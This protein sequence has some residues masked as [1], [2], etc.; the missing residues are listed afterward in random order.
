[1]SEPDAPTADAPDEALV[2]E[3]VDA[4]AG[5]PGG[6]SW[7]KVAILGV[8]LAFLGGSIGYLVGHRAE[9]ADPLSGTDVGF[10]QDMGLHHSQAVE[11]SLLLLDKDG[12]DR[13]LRSFAQ[14]III[15][16]RREIGIF[17]ATLDRFG[18]ATDPGDMVMGWMGHAV[19]MDQ[20]EGMASDAQMQQLRDATGADAEALWIALM[21]EH[22]LGGMHMADE[23]AR[24]GH[25]R[26]TVNLARAIVK[27]QR[28]E[29]V[30]LARLRARLALPI[31]KGFADPLQDPRLNPISA[32]AT[33]TT[34]GD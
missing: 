1:V 22:H 20:M 9:T 31:P 33:T 5:R 34:T 19:P 7:V 25:D 12:I 32:V 18:H 23:E 28:S 2:G 29:I 10:M 15:D 17:N 26:T 21:S 4:P 3:P 30:D 27:A 6:L 13:N 11:M 16:Q 24:H 8:A 14:E